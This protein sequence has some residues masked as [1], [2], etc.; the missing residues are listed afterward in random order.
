MMN[1]LKLLQKR[2]FINLQ[3]ND[4]SIFKLLFVGYDDTIGNI[5]QAYISKNITDD[6]I[7]SVCGYKRTHPLEDMIV[8]T[9]L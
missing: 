1:F 9:F 8:F 5:I 6:S 3:E 7:L 2:S 4:D